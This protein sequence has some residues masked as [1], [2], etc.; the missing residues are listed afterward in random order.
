MAVFLSLGAVPPAWSATLEEEA[1]AFKARVAA[2]AAKNTY[3]EHRSLDLD[4]DL[5]ALEKKAQGSPKLLAELISLRPALVPEFYR[6]T[7][8]RDPELFKAMRWSD[9]VAL[10][11]AAMDGTHPLLFQDAKAAWHAGADSPDFVFTEGG[12]KL[13]TPEITA[14]WKKFQGALEGSPESIKADMAAMKALLARIEKGVGSKDVKDRETATKGLALLFDNMSQADMAE[15]ARA[16]PEMLRDLLAGMNRARESTTP[17]HQKWLYQEGSVQRFDENLYELVNDPNLSQVHAL[18]RGL[19]PPPKMEDKDSAPG[20]PKADQ[21]SWWDALTTEGQARLSRNA[22]LQEQ[23]EVALGL[24]WRGDGEH[25]QGFLSLPPEVQELIGRGDK[26]ADPLSREEWLIETRRCLDQSKKVQEMEGLIKKIAGKGSQFEGMS[27]EEA[28]QDPDVKALTAFRDAHRE[29]MEKYSILKG[30]SAQY[31]L[32]MQDNLAFLPD[33]TRLDARSLGIHPD[34]LPHFDQDAKWLV[35]RTREI[36]GR[37][38]VGL[39]Y[40]TKWNYKDERGAVVMTRFWTSDAGPGGVPVPVNYTLDPKGA[41]KQRDVYLAKEGGGFQAVTEEGEF[42]ENGQLA[43]GQVK[44]GG[45]KK[46]EKVEP[47][48]E[49]LPD[50]RI[51]R[52]RRLVHESGRIPYRR[53]V[54]VFSKERRLLARRTS[55]IDTATG[56]ESERKEVYFD[57][58]GQVAALETATLDSEGKVLKGNEWFLARVK[59]TEWIFDP[60]TGEYLSAADPANAAQIERIVDA[61]QEYAPRWVNRVTNRE[62]NIQKTLLVGD[63]EWEDADPEDPGKGSMPTLIGPGLYEIQTDIDKPERPITFQ[64]EIGPLKGLPRSVRLEVLSGFVDRVYEAYKRYQPRVI[65]IGFWGGSDVAGNPQALVALLNDV[66]DQSDQAGLDPVV[67]LNAQDQG[68]TP[69]LI[70]FVDK[71]RRPVHRFYASYHEFAGYGSNPW[72]AGK[73]NKGKSV[74]RGLTVYGMGGDGRKGSIPLRHIVSPTELYLPKWRVSVDNYVFG[75]DW[76]STL[77]NLLGARQFERLDFVQCVFDKDG[78]FER[79]GDLV[80]GDWEQ[81]FAGPTV[82]KTVWDSVDKAGETIVAFAGVAIG[83]VMYAAAEAHDFTA[84][85][86]EDAVGLALEGSGD[87]GVAREYRK[88]LEQERVFRRAFKANLKESVVSNAIMNPLVASWRALGMTDEEIVEMEREHRGHYVFEAPNVMA[89]EAVNSDA[90]YE[91]AFWGGASAFTNFGLQTGKGL[92]VYGPLGN[93]GAPR[94]WV[95][96]GV[97]KVGPVWSTTAAGA[98]RIVMA[99]LAAPQSALLTG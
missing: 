60:E 98:P 22:M 49:E 46:F 1:A 72:G 66:V 45:E 2:E 99:Q 47:T 36:G 23:V 10:R 56:K 96:N 94:S 79:E 32:W 63:V 43:K 13:T 33:G 55:E 97:P 77:N 74:P 89:R 87:P 69:Y 5:A 93:I 41:I 39:E 64:I 92:A 15:L 59:P 53:I 25:A 61:L 70:T 85:A 48:E 54:E 17:G 30:M 44:Y 28:A 73:H 95:V 37:T 90:W 38:F 14:L 91:K 19:K 35:K 51:K 29:F 83:A 20:D 71:E 67:I 62:T 80:I 9:F 26:L 4:Q 31:T 18:M 68:K 81:T 50:G 86:V 24:L 7:A 78:K 34:T 21:V 16:D 82:F 12:R 58:Q 88:H 8:T 11:N 65:A 42:D 27:E 52:V 3:D 76:G 75:T 40:A 84:S 57:D 6:P